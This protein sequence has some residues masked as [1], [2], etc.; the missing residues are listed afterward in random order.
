LPILPEKEGASLEPRAGIAANPDDPR[1]IV[2]YR[3]GIMA[4]GIDLEVGGV[5]MEGV[6]GAMGG[7]ESEGIEE[8][9]EGGG[10]EG[11]EG[12][13]GGVETERRKR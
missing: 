5:S 7:V 1:D 11:A 9:V 10:T 3:T 2:G 6:V 4:T 12:A 8:A 13:V